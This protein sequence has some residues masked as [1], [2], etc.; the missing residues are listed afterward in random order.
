MTRDEPI[1]VA[2]DDQVSSRILCKTLEG[3]GYDVI[4]VDNGKAAWDIFNQ[5]NPPLLLILDWIMPGIDGLTLCRRIREQQIDIYPY[6]LLLTANSE[7]DQVITGLESGAD[8]YIVKPYNP[9][10]LKARISNGMRIIQMQKELIHT[11]D[12]L[13]VQAT[14][15][16]LTGLWNR[17]TIFELLEMELARKS[18][19]LKPTGVLMIDLDKFKDINDTHGHLVGDQILKEFANRLQQGVRAYDLVGRYGGDE[20]LIVLPD[21]SINQARI[22]A[23]RIVEQIQ[24]Y[25]IET[26]A[27]P[28]DVR[29]SVGATASVGHEQIRPDDLISRA[30]QALYRAKDDSSAQVAVLKFNPPSVYTPE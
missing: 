1:L 2:E 26:S 29:A 8:D 20:F 14:H 9:I 18:R 24:T 23:N 17:A 21:C 12:A 27:G 25:P 6:I 3:W 19:D 5:K 16:N 30:D 4:S 15:D 11:R 7:K 28:L 22:L 13:R 10:E